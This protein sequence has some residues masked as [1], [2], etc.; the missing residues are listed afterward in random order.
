L[1]GLILERGTDRPVVL[2]RVALVG[3]GDSVVAQTLSGA[4]GAFSLSSREAGEFLL[5]TTAL[6]YRDSRAGIFELGSGGEITLEIRLVPE[7]LEI[8]GLTVSPKAVLPKL[9]E[10]GFLKRFQGG[11]GHFLT[12]TDLERGTGRLLIDRLAK[13]P[14]VRVVRDS[15][16]LFNRGRPC[17]PKVYLDGMIVAWVGGEVETLIGLEDVE[18]IEVYR[19]VIETPPQFGGVNPEVCGAVV[20]WSKRRE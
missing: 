8:E 3:A 9:V 1:R 10:S 18:A 12:P 15:V 6:G 20:I 19:G 5:H 17:A 16:Y 2:A 11:I 14:G 4:S 7:P 13:I